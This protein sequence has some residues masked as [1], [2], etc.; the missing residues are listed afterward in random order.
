MNV[1][2]KSTLIKASQVGV[3]NVRSQSTSTLFT[4]LDRD[5]SALKQRLDGLYTNGRARAR[6]RVRV[7]VSVRVRGEG[8]FRTDSKVG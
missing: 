8:G 7:R 3:R 2:S 4:Y 5:E 6:A 1:K